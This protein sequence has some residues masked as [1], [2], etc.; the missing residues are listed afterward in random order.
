V[1]ITQV[2]GAQTIAE[3]VENAAILERLKVLG[4]GYAQGF[5]F[6]KPQPISWFNTEVAFLGQQR[7]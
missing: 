2:K 1:Q 6:G 5:Y 3:Y 4:V 7:R